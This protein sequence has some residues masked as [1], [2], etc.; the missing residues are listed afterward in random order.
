MGVAFRRAPFVA[1][2]FQS[3]IDGIQD[4]P[5]RSS[6]YPVKEERIRGVVQLTSLAPTT[7]TF[8]VG[9]LPAVGLAQAGS[10]FGVPRGATARRGQ[11]CSTAPV[12]ALVA[13][14]V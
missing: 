4:R 5:S 9:C 14:F 8:E 13:I 11:S 10:M 12:P 1:F 7:S 2:S 6:C 3:V